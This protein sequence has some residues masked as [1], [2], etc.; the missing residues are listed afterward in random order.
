MNLSTA[1]AQI[2]NAG[3]S[4]TNPIAKIGA[5]TTDLN[6]INTGYTGPVT[7]SAGRLNVNTALGAAATIAV[8]DGAAL[9][10]EQT[11]ASLTLG[12]ATGS[13]L[14][15]DP[16]TLAKL[17]A[18]TLTVPTGTTTTLEFSAP[19]PGDGTYPVLSFGSQTGT[20]AFALG[21]G[22][23]NYRSATINHTATAVDVVIANTKALVWLGTGP[24]FTW[25]I[26]TTSNWDDAGAPGTPE[27]F[28]Q[29][30]VVTFDDSAIIGGATA[31]AVTPGVAPADIQVS[32]TTNNYT[33]TSTGVGI[34]GGK[35]SK[36]GSTTLT[37]VG[38]NTY[39]GKTTVA[40]GT[41]SIAAANSLGNGAVGNSIALSNGG[42]LSI[43]ANTA[44]DLGINRSITVGT[45][46]GE[47]NV[48]GAIAGNT[49]VNYSVPGNI[50][51]TAALKFSATGANATAATTA[52]ANYVLS[53]SNS[54]YTG[55]ITIESTSSVMSQ[56][57]ISSQAAVPSASAINLNYPAGA[58]TSGNATT[59]T[60]ASGVTLPVG[61]TINM[62]TNANGAIS[63][64]SQITTTGN[65]V[66]DGTITISGN[67]GSVVN[68]APPTAGT[69][70]TLNGPITEGVTPFGTAGSPTTY[71]AM[72]FRSAGNTVVN[73]QI[74]MPNGMFVRVDNTGTTT[75]NSTGNIW[76]FTDIRSASTL[77]IGATNALAIA[78]P[79]RI[80]QSTDAGNSFF[81][82]N[83]FN[84][85]VGGL[86]YIAGNGANTRGIVN[87]GASPSTLTINN[88]A[89]FVYGNGGGTNPAGN[90]S[91][92]IAIVK[93]G[94][95]SQT[96]AGAANTYTGNVTV[97][98]GTLVAGGNQNST[99]LG[100]PTTAGRTVTVNNAGTTLS[101]TTNNVFGNG[102]GNLNMPALAINSGVVT[103]T[104]Y[105]V[106][107]PISLS[108]GTLT[109]SSTDAGGYEG[110][111][112]RGNV[113]VGGTAQ[114]VISTG[115]AKA[116]H[117]NT[118]TVFTVADAIAG[119]TADL[120]VSAPLRN[121][122]ADFAS[123]TGGLT[124]D[125][126][127]TMELSATNTYTGPTLI[128]DGVL[129]VSGSISGSAVTVNGATAVLGGTGTVGATTL[130]N[131]G[132]IN[133]GAS[134]GILTIGG[135]F[136]MSSGT[137]L[138]AE[139]DGLT[140][141]TQYDQLSVTGTVTLAGSTLSLSGA[142]NTGGVV[143]N[144]LF[145]II[146]ND[147]AGDAVV[148][149]FAGITEGASVYTGGGQEFTLSYVGGD[150][151]DVVLT[152]VPEP[153]SA[154]MLLSGMGML[155][156]LQRRRRKA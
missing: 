76:A 151:N 121:Q 98:A 45:G 145:T 128:T 85:E 55:P 75:V 123:A 27:K 126:P 10:G 149:T 52:L 12:T 77:K 3:F 78:A 48:S 8:A 102:V 11:V 24:A 87:N 110:F 89:N 115:N 47:L 22:A 53:G 14:F 33:L 105:N 90:I 103:S 7:V 81:D 94:A 109:Q 112:F 54:A 79:L 73:G 96:L 122:S 19:L 63:Q 5:G 69:T 28:Y 83:G 154:I 59:L 113:A 72:L 41:V 141:G 56:L 131:G 146:L 42:K 148:G 143:T 1:G 23:S 140:V 107:G 57:T 155:I 134:P 136:T 86:D 15:F 20:G 82:M 38:A 150:G 67:T 93:N 129:R 130:L 26:N 114:S 97:N 120:L 50:S 118:N 132:S 101:F 46:G 108:G 92:N 40:G 34:A 31:V 60:L 66:I 70:L 91:G 139:I 142:F 106:L 39:G 37:L 99:A 88:P 144:D 125:G 95:G 147:G 156:G 25:D 29:A 138:N 58:V 84:Q 62:T 43:S 124:K 16:T 17:T 49:T 36:D 74:N 127:G 30:D 61:T 44:T 21:G 135:N 119:S 111:Q 153:G 152:A 4:G 117:L 137:S 13:T 6:G 71:G 32:G 65:S 18:T 68:F 100:S 133:P 9:G 51:G 35:L 64:R 104:R 116:N 80:G 2:L